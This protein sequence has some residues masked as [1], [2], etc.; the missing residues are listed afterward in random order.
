MSSRASIAIGSVLAFCLIAGC[1][2]NAGMGPPAMEISTPPG[3]T[4]MSSDNPE[5]PGAPPA[6]APMPAT[7]PTNP[8]QH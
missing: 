6:A 7:I 1:S 3:V 2:G 4:Q 8:S 5:I